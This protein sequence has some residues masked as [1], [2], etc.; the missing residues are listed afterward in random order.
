MPLNLNLKPEYKN[1]TITVKPNN[2]TTSIHINLWNLNDTMTKWLID[3]GYGHIFEENETEV[4][5]EG[6]HSLVITDTTT[7]CNCKN[8]SKR[9]K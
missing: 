3:K 1:K 7:D 4:V 5:N 6:E 2:H 8:K 9:K